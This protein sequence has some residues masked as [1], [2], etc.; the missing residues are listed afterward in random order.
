MTVFAGWDMPV[1]YAGILAE[2][3]HTRGACSVFDTG[4]MGEFELRGP[5]AAADLERLLTLRVARLRDGQCRYGYLLDE[6]GG[7]LDD[8]TCYRLGPERFWLVVNAG[9]RAAD[10]EWVRARLS[11]D[12]SFEDLSARTA[13]LDVQGPAS[14]AAFARA[15]GAPPPPLGYFRLAETALGGAPALVSRTGYTGEW[16][17]E[18]YVPA[19]RAVACW[20]RLLGPG[21]AKPAG[22]GA[23]DTL[24]LEMGYALYGHELSRERTPVAASGAAFV[25][26]AKDFVGCEAVRRELDAGPAERLVG[27]ALEGR[28]A[29]RPP[30]GVCGPGGRRVGTVTSG[31]FAPSLGVAVALAYVE[32][33][34]SAPGTRLEVETGGARVAATVTP[35]PFHRAGTARAPRLP[36]PAA[37]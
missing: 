2:H 13:K 21:G 6:R 24:R 16:G 15:F 12:T 22:L 28:R 30:A 31:S 5:R 7:V 1:R 29:A 35:L 19:D 18:L 14:A 4:H 11:P 36:A 17:Y 37:S 3:A 34:L 27:L 10:A 23:R 25:D 9:T 26:P 32:A 33:A 20:R 8:L